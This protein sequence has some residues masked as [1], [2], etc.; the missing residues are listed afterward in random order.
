MLVVLAHDGDNAWGGGFSYYME[1]TPNLVS[2]RPEQR[3]TAPPSSSTSRTTP[4]PPTTSSH[5]EDGAWVNADGDFGAPQ[6]LNWNWPL[7]NAQGQVDIANGWA[8]DARNWAVITAA[9]NYVDTAEQISGGGLNLA[10]KS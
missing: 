7:V 8:E 1:A 9:Q 10:R 4:S 6:M 2:S 5:V 3:G